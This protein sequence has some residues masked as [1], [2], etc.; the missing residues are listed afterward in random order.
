MSI[1]ASHWINTGMRTLKPHEWL[2]WDIQYISGLYDDI[3]QDWSMTD[4]DRVEEIEEGIR[5]KYGK[6]AE[7]I[8]QEITYLPVLEEK[9]PKLKSF[10]REMKETAN[11]QLETMLTADFQSRED[12]LELA[13]LYHRMDTVI[14]GTIRIAEKLDTQETLESLSLP[15][16]KKSRFRRKK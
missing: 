6:L 14:G 8:D 12:Q 1:R 15:K 10:L 16:S 2:Y 4:P 9:V 11:E 5:Y 13:D 7:A 3:K